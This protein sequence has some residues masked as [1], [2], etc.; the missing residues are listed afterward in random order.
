[1]KKIFWLICLS[2][3]IAACTSNDYTIKG[4]VEQEVNIGDSVYLQYVENNR[5]VTLGR[6]AVKDGGFVFSG[7][8]EK[9]RLCYIVSF[10]DKKVR[11]NAEVFVESGNITVNINSKRPTLSGTIL[12]ERLQEYKDS[13]DIINTMFV[14]Y[15][16]KSKYPQLSEKAAE[17]ADKGMKVL[18]LVR[19][20]YVNRF[21]EKNIDNSV[22]AY[23]LTKNYETIEPETGIDII[24]RMPFEIKNDTV[25][26]H[27]ENTFRN[28]IATAEGRIFID[29]SAVDV[30]GTKVHL[31]D[32]VG[33]GK[34]TV[35]NFWGSKGRNVAKEISEIKSLCN[36]YKD[37]VCFVGF[38]LDT[39]VDSWNK[40]VQEN[41]MSW[42][43]IS[44]LSGWN[45][46]A[47]FSYGINS[48]PYNIIFGADGV[49][50]RKGVHSS[51]LNKELGELFKN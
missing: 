9:P 23:I 13:I 31:S 5:V 43:Q 4:T 49:I 44:D 48:Y 25:V 24:S 16:D 46:K 3:F 37:K 14:Q 50:L 28:K 7:I 18:G 41:E 47:V 26:K 22:C 29:F 1:M 27:I 36:I 51:L 6:S 10:V 17:E 34:I 38:S 21:L 11:S 42:L 35:L 15:Y 20:E 32:Y 30:N 33:N 12:N 19:N 45:S 8:C 40:A 39:D 2:V